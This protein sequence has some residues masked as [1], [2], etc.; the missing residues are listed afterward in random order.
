ML[1]LYTTSSLDK[2]KLFGTILMVISLPFSESLKSISMFLILF[3]FFVQLYKK[4]IKIEMSVIH[5]GF[6]FLLLSALISSI[7]AQNTVKSLRGAKDILFYIIPFF[8]VCSIN[9]KKNIRVILWSLYISTALSALF[10]I[11]HSIQIH[12]PL[13]IHA[14]GNQNYTAMYLMI[15]IISMIS[16]IIFSDKET[17][18]SKMMLGIFT[19]S[20]I[21]AVVMTAMR[22]SFLGLFLSVMILLFSSGKQF[23]STKLISLVLL[24]LI[25]AIMYFYKPMWLKLFSTTSLVSRLYIWQHALDLLKESPVTGI[26][27]NHFKYTFPLSYV[28]EAGSSYFDAHNVYLQTASQ[29]GLLGLVSIFLIISG[30][31]HQWLKLKTISGFERAVKYSA[32]GGFLVT[33]IGGIFDTTLHHEH[34]IVFTLL[35]GLMIGLFTNKEYSREAT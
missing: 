20:T 3:I 26:G 10:G 17:K 1:R 29:M 34:A 5:Y 7:F 12:R 6:I 21:V 8:I 13:E 23:K 16:T 2:V 9:N 24:S 33:F 30:F 31:L 19:T 27:L 25:P 11:F 14:L 18:F 15:V 35:T 32:L 28:P 4:E 22:S